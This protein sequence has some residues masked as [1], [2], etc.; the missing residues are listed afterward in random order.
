MTDL[1]ALIID[2]FGISQRIVRAGI[3]VV[4][5]FNVFAPDDGVHVAFVQLPQDTEGRLKRLEVMQSFMIWKAATAFTLASELAEPDAL[6]VVAVTRDGA[7]AAIQPIDREP[8]GFRPLSWFDDKH[9]DRLILDLLPPREKFKL[10]LKSLS[11][12][13]SLS[14]TG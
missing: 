6:M 12:C 8:L 11:S 14:K 9:I 3:K 13:A 7:A 5:R 4:P 1:T 2:E 10:P